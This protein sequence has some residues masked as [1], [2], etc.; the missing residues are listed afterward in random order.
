MSKTLICPKEEGLYWIVR[1]DPG[2]CQ[3]EIVRWKDGFFQ[4]DHPTDPLVHH[5]KILSW[6]GPIVFKDS[7]PLPPREWVIWNETRPLN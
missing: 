3:A 2:Q 4:T 5:S 1:A 6:A 7:K